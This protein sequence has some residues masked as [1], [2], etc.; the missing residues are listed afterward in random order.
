MAHSDRPSLL[1]T[2][3]WSLAILLAMVIFFGL[4]VG[5]ALT[6]PASLAGHGY[7]PPAAPADLTEFAPVPGRQAPGIDLARALAGDPELR[8][9]AKAEYDKICVA[10]H[11]PQ[12]KGDGPA[13]AALGARDFSQ[14]TGWKNGP[15]LTGIFETLTQ[16][17][18]PG[19]PAYDTYGPAQR[20]ALA[21]VVQSFMAFPAPVAGAAEVAAL[22]ARHSLSAGVREPARVPVRVALARLAEE[23]VAPTL[24][25]ETLPADLRHLVLDA[26]RA[27]ATLAGLRGRSGPELAAALHAGAPGN[28]FSLALGTLGGSD[29]QRLAAA[30][31]G[32]LEL[33]AAH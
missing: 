31:P 21:H 2:L 15:A 29:W 27:G 10:C 25:R 17:L 5:P 13:G 7:Q 18:P 24:R 26:G 6:R 4:L 28:G 1:P 16:G 19:M 23:A 20:L 30:L 11:G 14:A 9:W 8:G 22:D 3:A 12:G 33:A 32:A